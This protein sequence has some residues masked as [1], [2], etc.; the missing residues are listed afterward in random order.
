MYLMMVGFAEE[1]AALDDAG[2]A[3]ATR[4]YKDL[5]LT[6]LKAAVDK[7]YDGLA[8]PD[9]QTDF[10]ELHDEPEF[11]SLVQRAGGSTNGK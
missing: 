2:R 6:R 4:K 7:G 3:A 8:S 11:Q 9:A 10:A 5:A 1:D